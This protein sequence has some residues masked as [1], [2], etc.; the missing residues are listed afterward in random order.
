MTVSI[1][2]RVSGGALAVVGLPLM[3][4]TLAAL[5]GGKDSFAVLVHWLWAGEGGGTMQTLANA[6][7][8]FALIGLS[9][10]L[11][12]HILSGLR[13]FVLDIGAGYELASNAAWSWI[14]MIGSIVLTIAFWAALL[15]R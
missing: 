1:L 2:H 13:H 15:L 7:G 11:F 8:K 9:W 12:E 4:W 5:A 6:F 10:A 14:V 3:L